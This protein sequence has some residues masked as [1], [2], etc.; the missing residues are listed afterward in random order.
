MKWHFLKIWKERIPYLNNIIINFSYNLQEYIYI[1]IILRYTLIVWI[2]CETFLVEFYP[3]AS[4]RNTIHFFKWDIMAA[5]FLI[6]SS[7]FQVKRIAFI[8]RKLYLK[9]RKTLTP[10][11][12]SLTYTLN[13][14]IIYGRPVLTFKCEETGAVESLDMRWNN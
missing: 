12:F 13:G 9:L 3:I 5:R 11:E 4:I 14:Y 8:L 1:Y 10:V 6:S 2:F 7:K